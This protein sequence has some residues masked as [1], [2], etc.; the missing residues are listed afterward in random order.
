MWKWKTVCHAAR[1]H[2]LSR[3]TPSAPS[4]SVARRGEPLRRERRRGQI[5][6]LD[7][8]QVPRVPARD[9]QRVA[10]GRR[11]DVHERDRALVLATICAGH[12]AGDDLAEDAVGIAAIAAGAYRS[13]RR[14]SPKQLAA[15]A[16]ASS[17]PRDLAGEARLLELRQQLAELGPG[18]ACRARAAS[19]SPRI[20]GPR[21]A[22]A[23][24][25]APRR[26]ARARARGGVAIA[27][28]ALSP[29]RRQPVGDAE[30]R[31]VD[32]DRLAGA[33]GSRRSRG[34]ERPLVD[35]EPEPQV[36]ARQ[37]GDVLAQPLARPAAAAA[38]RRASAAPAAS[39]PMNVTR[40]SGGHARA[41]A[42]WRCRAAARRSAAPGRASARWRAARRAARRPAAACSPSTAPGIALR[43]RSSRP[44][45]R[46]CGRGRRGGGSGS[47]RRRAAR[48]LRQHGVA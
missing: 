2:E 5:L 42:A 27:S 35:E 8:E 46:A 22:G 15:S 24:R 9:H 32:L 36:V 47:A 29:A 43:A 7:L 41:S 40:P 16:I 30:H 44:A 34:G 23:P 12:L 14:R 48:Q 21:R 20:G 4:R 1:P 39:W 11:V 31:D 18:L 45:P 26:A 37:R 28:S 13:R 33:S 19:S 6:G 10:A 3:L 17:R 38:P 25:A